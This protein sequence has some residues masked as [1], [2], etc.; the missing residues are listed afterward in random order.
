MRPHDSPIA[1]ILA[2]F[3][4]VIEH[5]EQDA[6]ERTKNERD[7]LWVDAVSRHC[8]VPTAMQIAQ[9]F[10]SPTSSKS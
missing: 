6:V 3:R 5:A 1:N 2:H 7:D 9:E 4:V 10:I 8:D